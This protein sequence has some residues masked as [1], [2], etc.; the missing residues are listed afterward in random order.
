MLEHF[1]Y[2]SPDDPRCAVQKHHVAFLVGADSQVLNEAH[3]TISL[4]A[5]ALTMFLRIDPKHTGF[6]SIGQEAITKAFQWLVQTSLEEA[7]G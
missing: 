5:H 1:R 2:T 6:P 4:L 7:I 3:H